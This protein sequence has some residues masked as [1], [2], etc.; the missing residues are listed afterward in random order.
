VRWRDGCP[1]DLRGTAEI[2]LYLCIWTIPFVGSVD[3]R[4]YCLTYG[5][6]LWVPSQTFTVWHTAQFS[7][8]FHFETGDGAFV[9]FQGL[10]INIRSLFAILKQVLESFS[11]IYRS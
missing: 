8:L 4:L 1:F 10:E 2:I 7:L 5:A 11:L 3:T 9:L 6:A